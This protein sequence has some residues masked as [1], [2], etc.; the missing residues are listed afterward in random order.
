MREPI[1]G[2]GEKQCFVQE[3][4]ERTFR[5]SRVERGLRRTALRLRLGNDTEED[6]R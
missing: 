5:T 3:G 2:L 1:H 6:P 4:A